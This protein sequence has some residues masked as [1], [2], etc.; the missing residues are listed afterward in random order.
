[1]NQLLTEMD[2]VEERR[3]V[4][5]IG[6][7]NRPD[8]V[9]PALLRPGRLD[10][11]L[12]VGL[13]AAADRL[14]ILRTLTQVHVLYILLLC[15]RTVRVSKKKHFPASF[16]SQII[17]FLFNTV[18]RVL[19]LY[20]YTVL[21][22]CSVNYTLLCVNVTFMYSLYCIVSVLVERN[23]ASSSLEPLSRAT[24][25]GSGLQWLQVLLLQLPSLQVYSTTVFGGERLMAV[26]LYS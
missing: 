4:F 21:V 19:Y 26:L 6:A 8:I 2:G 11:V 17:L 5:L 23:S 20:Q 12:F 1:M 18:V 3:Q 9:D 24:R 7:T 14:D 22:Y 10:K 15:I 25:F 13:P 16:Q